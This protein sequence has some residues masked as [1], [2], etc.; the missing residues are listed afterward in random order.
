METQTSW[1]SSSNG[2]PLTQTSP[3]YANPS[4]LPL[5]NATLGAEKEEGT[6]GTAGGDRPGD[7][8]AGLTLKPIPVR[9]VGTVVRR[10]VQDCAAAVGENEKQ[11]WRF[12]IHGAKVE[13]GGGG[14][15]GPGS[16]LRG[17]ASASVPTWR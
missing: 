3:L 2:D 1:T 7:R 15:A 13:R 12:E 14:G 11:G 6:H 4:R 9:V 17:A 10:L 8:W 16:Y 5:Q